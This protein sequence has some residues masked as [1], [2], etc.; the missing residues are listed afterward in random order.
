MWENIQ[1]E[2][3]LIY[4]GIKNWINVYYHTTK[5]HC[6]NGKLFRSPD[7]ILAQN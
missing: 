7:G 3:Q 2:K 4:L 1:S 5:G 6:D